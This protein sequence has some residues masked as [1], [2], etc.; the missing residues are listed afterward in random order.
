MSRGD[1]QNTRF[2]LGGETP[3]D[4]V[5]TVQK[6][7]GPDADK[8]LQKYKDSFLNAPY[9][10]VHGGNTAESSG[11][12]GQQQRPDNAWG[13]SFGGGESSGSSQAA[14]GGGNSFPEDPGR[15]SG[16]APECEH[17]AKIWRNPPDK[18]WKGWFCS[19]RKRSG[20]CAAEWI[21]D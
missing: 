15:P 5:A 17:G 2:T 12:G 13:N 18:D 8:V 4:F 3:D 20:S 16:A 7:F 19:A 10:D 1:Y 11:G 9:F 21:N 6:V 14:G